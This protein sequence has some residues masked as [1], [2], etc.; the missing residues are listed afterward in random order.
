MEST[1]NE[2]RAEAKGQPIEYHGQL[3]YGVHRRRIGRRALIRLRFV[4][5]NE[6]VRQGLRLKVSAGHLFIYER[7][8]KDLVVWS[9]TAPELT[10]VQCLV[11]ARGSTLSLWN[12]WQDD[13]GTMQAW[14]RY[15][16]MLVKETDASVELR[17]S[18]G[19]GD[20]DFD[21]LIVEVSFSG[22]ES[23]KGNNP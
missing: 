16:G 2:R 6:H 3:V 11:P 19:L 18:D 14:L 8:L 1:F 15:S 13:S 22:Q 9:D 4:A 23:E 10:V 20:P 7:K 17:C 21:D 12:V 5:T